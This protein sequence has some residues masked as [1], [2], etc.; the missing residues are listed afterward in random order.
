MFHNLLE[1]QVIPII[2]TATMI[3]HEMIV[4]D[5]WLKKGGCRGE[6]GQDIIF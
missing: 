3:I 5:I 4:H 2:I 6:G 1:Y